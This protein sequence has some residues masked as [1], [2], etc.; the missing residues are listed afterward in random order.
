[1]TTDIFGKSSL[2]QAVLKSVE[3][4]RGGGQFLVFS[5]SLNGFDAKN[6]VISNVSA[7]RSG[8]DAINRRYFNGNAMTFNGDQTA[9]DAKNKLISNVADPVSEYDSIN[10]SFLTKNAIV[11]DENGKFN[12]TNNILTNVQDPKLD[13]DAVTKG[14]LRKYVNLVINTLFAKDLDVRSNKIVNCNR[15]TD[16]FDVVNKIFLD[17]WLTL[18]NSFNLLVMIG[19]DESGFFIF[20]PYETSFFII[21][22]DCSLRMTWTN[23]PESDV[24]IH[25]DNHIL[26]H[27]FDKNYHSY[28]KGGHLRV[29]AKK[30]INVQEKFYL[31]IAINCFL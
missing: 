8:T 2:D 13:S 3:E 21:P 4:L 1:M 29:K 10:K 16:D 11:K 9:F 19:I 31:E 22:F 7:P 18:N 30:K 26:E 6:N 28:T 15:P 12:A 24:E 17:Q 27:F 14:F 25:N 20:H 23:L 5:E